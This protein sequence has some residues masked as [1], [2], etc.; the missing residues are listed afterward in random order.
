MNHLFEEMN[1]IGFKIYTHKLGVL[2]FAKKALPD[3]IAHKNILLHFAR[4][5]WGS[6]W[7]SFMT[8]T[9]LITFPYDKKDEPEVYFNNI[10]VEKLGI[11]KVYNGESIDELLEFRERYKEKVKSIKK[12]LLEK[13]G[14]LNGA[15]YTAEKILDHYLNL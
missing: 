8:E 10:C 2:P 9:P 11:G 3:V 1:R 13:Y 6:A 12:K 4:I 15:E 7:L 5:G 14:T